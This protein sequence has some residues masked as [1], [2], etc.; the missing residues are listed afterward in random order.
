MGV[1]SLDLCTCFFFFVMCFKTLKLI[2]VI[3]VVDDWTYASGDLR[4]VGFRFLIFYEL[5]DS[6]KL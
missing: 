1:G 5:W 4:V 6:L 3:E 2:C